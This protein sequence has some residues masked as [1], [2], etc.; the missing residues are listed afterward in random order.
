MYTILTDGSKKE[1]KTYHQLAAVTWTWMIKIVSN[2]KHQR[3]PPAAPTAA[4]F[5]TIFDE[6]IELVDQVRF[7]M[8]DDAFMLASCRWNSSLK[9]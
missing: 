9:C 3:A 7:F 8:N 4:D 6:L 5:L 2:A 1:K